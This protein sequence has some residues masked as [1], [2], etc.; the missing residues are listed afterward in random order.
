MKFIKFMVAT[1][2]TMTIG[3]SAFAETNLTAETASPGG[4]THLSPAHLTEIAG[5]QGIANIQRSL[6]RHF[7]A[8]FVTAQRL[9]TKIAWKGCAGDL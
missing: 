7:G 6:A 8:I 4:A 3:V 2:A 1:V 5:T 9:I